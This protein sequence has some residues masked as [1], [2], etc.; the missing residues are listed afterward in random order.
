[1]NLM[2]LSNRTRPPL[3]TVQESSMKVVNFSMIKRPLGGQLNY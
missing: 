3:V 1:M 2:K